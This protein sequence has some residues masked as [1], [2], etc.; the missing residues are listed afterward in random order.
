MLE[1]LQSGN[2]LIWNV[3]FE[4]RLSTSIQLILSYDGR[5]TG[6]D[7]LVNTARAE[8]RAIF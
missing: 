8:I 1:G 6:T 5:K 3:G 7:K 4:Q 2:N